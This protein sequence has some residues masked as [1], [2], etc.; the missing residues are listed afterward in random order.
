MLIKAFVIFAFILTPLCAYARPGD[1]PPGSADLQPDEIS[2]PKGPITLRDALSLALT[3]N[4]EL[5]T[6]S[7]E[8]RAREAGALQAGLF[9]NPE[10]ESLLEDF[11]G[12][13]S[14]EGFKGTETTVLLSQLVP[15]WGKVS[16]RKRLADLD[17]DLA[18]WDYEAA[19]LDVLT[20]T[21]KAFAGV[22]AAQSQL[23][24]TEELNS[25]AK[26]VYDTVAEQASAGEISPI[27]EK[28]AKVA[29]SQSEIRLD[30]ARRELDTARKQLAF[31]W[32]GAGPLFDK[33]VGTLDEVS[34][35]P[36]YD[37]LQEF[38]SQNPDI[39]RWSAEM[40][41]REAALRLEEARAVPDPVISGGYRHISEKDDNAFVVGL[42]IPLPVFDRNQ[43]GILEAR[44]RISKG[45]EEKRSAVA[46]VSASLASAYQDLA[47]AYTEAQ[48][49]RNEVLREAE[50]AYESIFEGYREGKFSLLDV[51]RTV[52]DADFQYVQALRS[53][54]FSLA[55]VE[56]LTGTPIQ[57]M[58]NRS[59]GGE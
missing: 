21:A 10:I 54:H 2:E 14:V 30:R 3:H 25:L 22:L 53:Y 9:P 39:A 23:E 46:A 38:I 8:V 51:Q 42:S 56:R 36:A 18:G 32:G 45:E 16:K 29:F 33:A 17:T 27:Q 48:V 26:R 20:D 5:R 58:Q 57:E 40:N 44:R 28:R 11:G 7:W 15:L 4:P 1:S 55:D 34:P 31:M 37:R 47:A 59:Q 41:Q 43:G 6:F 19:R 24:L 35:V 52:F 50:S 49:L 12:T 13:G